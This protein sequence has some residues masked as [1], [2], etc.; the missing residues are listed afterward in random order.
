[1]TDI[2]EGSSICIS[3]L[4]A[5]DCNT[6]FTKLANQHARIGI[7]HCSAKTSEFADVFVGRDN[8][9]T[10]DAAQKVI[11]DQYLSTR[12]WTFQER[13]VSVASL[14]YTNQGMV[15]ECADAECIETKPWTGPWS[16]ATLKKQWAKLR[17][18]VPYGPRRDSNDAIEPMAARQEHLLSWYNFVEKYNP[19]KLTKDTDKFPAIAG[20]ARAFQQQ[21]S[22]R[23]LAGLWDQDLLSG[24]SWSRTQDTEPLRLTARYRAPSWSWA[25]VDG[26]ISYKLHF[27]T[28]Y[29]MPNLD[30]QV[31]DCSAEETQK[32]SFG[33]IWTASL[34]ATGLLQSARLEIFTPAG[35]LQPHA[36]T[37]VE[38]IIPGVL[39]ECVLDR[40]EEWPEGCCECFF[41]RLGIFSS[42]GRDSV[43]WLL[44]SPTDAR[45]SKY[46]RIGI[47]NTI[48]WGPGDA[49]AI[50][51]DVF[52]AGKRTQLTLV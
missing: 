47:G 16:S 39:V 36:A 24:L 28:N 49:R 14:H 51:Y 2:Y 23:Y 40:P 4:S 34:Q 29:K 19:R 7:L 3:A 21:T 26:Q 27:V 17:V 38:G 10:E 12:G 50:D 43:A 25:S 11:E 8:S 44:I 30:L 9:I 52:V 6:G 18:G 42:D 22:M 15:W 13:L 33:Q 31:H 48:A 45:E 46:R 1:M 32:G 20:V 5:E 35:L 37:M 41:L